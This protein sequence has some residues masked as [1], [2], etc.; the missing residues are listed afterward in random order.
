MIDGF[1]YLI[2]KSGNGGRG[3][4]TQLDMREA[5][6]GLGMRSDRVT[7]DRLYL[8]FKRYNVNADDRLSYTE[9]TQIVCP[10]H[11]HM[12]Y[13]LKH[14]PE[15]VRGGFTDKE[16]FDFFTNEKFIA[17]LDSAI[18]TEVAMETIR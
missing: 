1:G 3:Y 15:G 12:D 5:L 6:M 8:L 14:R 17:V 9:F 11:P 13:V 18:E 2:A 7:M 4:L 16:I 10:M